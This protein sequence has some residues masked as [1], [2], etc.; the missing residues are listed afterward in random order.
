MTGLCKCGHVEE[1]HAPT[2]HGSVVES[3][4]GVPTDLKC[5]CLI[6]RRE[7]AAKS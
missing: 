3:I 4:N 7:D 2:C 5:P 1:L 6:F